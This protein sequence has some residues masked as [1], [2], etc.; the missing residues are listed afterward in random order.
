MSLTR[1]KSGITILTEDLAN[2]WYGGLFGT[3]E[4]NL[5]DPDDPLVAGH[6]HDGAR[7]NGHAQKINLSSHVTGIL[8][9]ASSPIQLLILTEDGRIVQDS[10][11]NILLK[12][13]P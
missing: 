3:T 7:N 13:T 9:A 8:S 5:L 1:Y 4:G 10:S 12:E 6:V 11:G 2:S